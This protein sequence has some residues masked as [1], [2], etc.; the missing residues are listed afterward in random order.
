M[1]QL[2]V[3]DLVRCLAIQHEGN[4]SIL[5]HIYVYVYIKLHSLCT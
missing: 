3:C 5:H 4:Q 1:L 2:D